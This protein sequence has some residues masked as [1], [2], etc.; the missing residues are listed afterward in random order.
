[1]IKDYVYLISSKYVNSD[2]PV[3][4]VYFINGV[5][6]ESTIADLRYFG[7]NDNSYTFTS[8]AAL[9]VKNGDFNHKNYLISLF[10][11]L[12]CIKKNFIEGKKKYRR[13][14]QSIS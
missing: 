9:N 6:L 4:P 3:L 8:V 14:S 2:D 10:Q 7:Y 1:M 12:K 11:H 5:E 13:W